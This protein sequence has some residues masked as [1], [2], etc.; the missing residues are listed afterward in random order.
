MNFEESVNIPFRPSLFLNTFSDVELTI[1]S[2]KRAPYWSLRTWNLYGKDGKFCATF[3]SGTDK[4]PFSVKLLMT[5]CH[6]SDLPKSKLNTELYIFCCSGRQKC[7]KLHRY[8]P[9]FSKKKI[10]GWYPQTP[11]TGK[12][13]SPFPR[14]LP[15]AR[16]HRGTFTELPWRWLSRVHFLNFGLC[17]SLFIRYLYVWFRMAEWQTNNIQQA[18]VLNFSSAC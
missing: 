9:L 16:L 11:I 12:A 10:L 3:K 18:T 13:G 6:Q 1:C 2:G 8:A 4:R 5:W 7:T 15:S 17:F 14:P